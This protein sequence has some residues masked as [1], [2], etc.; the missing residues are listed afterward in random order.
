[1][2]IPYPTDFQSSLARSNLPVFAM[3]PPGTVSS[4]TT[5]DLCRCTRRR[6]PAAARRRKAARPVPSAIIPSDKFPSRDRYSCLEPGWPE[7]FC[8]IVRNQK[9]L[10]HRGH[11]GTLRKSGFPSVTFLCAL[12]LE[13]AEF[14]SPAA[15][16]W[17]HFSI[18]LSYLQSLREPRLA[19]NPDCPLRHSALVML[20]G[21][22]TCEQS[23]YP[24][25]SGSHRRSQ[26]Y[27]SCN[28]HSPRQ[29]R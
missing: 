6:C 12:W 26:K 1:M 22:S 2:V 4:V 23:I 11:R 10:N 24:A 8:G 3:A 25:G 18:T 15:C 29:R 28:R 9:N 13:L 21:C 19:S 20:H 14:P 17:Q 27:F 16:S 7:R 5:A